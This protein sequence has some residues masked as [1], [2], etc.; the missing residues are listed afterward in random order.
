[1]AHEPGRLTANGGV[2]AGKTNIPML[3]LVRYYQMTHLSL[4]RLDAIQSRGHKKFN[5]DILYRSFKIPTIPIYLE[6]LKNLVRTFI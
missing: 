2:N 5:K 1:M 4:F 6:G 3:H